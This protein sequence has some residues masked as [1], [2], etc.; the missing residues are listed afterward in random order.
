MDLK[1]IKMNCIE[2]F[3][4]F[5]GNVNS[6]KLTEKKNIDKSLSLIYFHHFRNL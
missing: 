4:F 3:F 2:N 5:F 1:C 6:A